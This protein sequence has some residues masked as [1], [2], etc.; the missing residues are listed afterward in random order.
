MP[1]FDVLRI[2]KN[3]VSNKL[4]GVVHL[5]S[6]GK[7]KGDVLLSYITESFT[8]TPSE[9]FT[10]PHTN[11]WECSEI[12][13]LF[14]LRGYAV[15]VI[16]FK[17]TDFIPRKKYVA[18]IDIM[19]NLERLTKYLPTNCKKVMH[20]TSAYG[21]FQNTVE[22][23]RLLE[24][25]RRRNISLTPHRTGVV[26]NNP[27]YADFLEGLGNQTTHATY[28]RF[29]KHIYPIPISVAREFDLPEQK[30]FETARTHFLWFGGGGAIL[31]GLDLVI[32]AF[33]D[34]PKLSL[35][36][37]GPLA[38]EKDFVQAYKYELAL[39][40]IKYYPRPHIFPDGEM[41]SG[42][43]PFLD[44]ANRCSTLIYPS[45][46]EGTSGA[47]VQAMHAGIIPIITKQ[48]GISED[49]PVII[50]DTPTVESIRD[51]AIQ[52]TKTDPLELRESAY[53][54]WGYARAHH[55]Q[56]TFS[57]AYSRF[58]DDILHL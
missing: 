14:T 37:V 50:C 38:R 2:Y 47:V 53:K 36:I 56:K 21:E 9:R 44:I 11:K 4:F 23:Q 7:K 42:D 49:A 1:T 28:A 35:H 57:E 5:P 48:T 29:K 24:L 51:L 52:I 26:S 20:I 43:I 40:N 13:R 41:R 27:A 30:N 58:I 15:D 46:S 12:V 16:N 25:K 17:N 10:D 22:K 39:P 8:C 18:C 33:A 55:T 45:A 31:K 19:Q 32:E 6:I 3:K 34:L 54:A